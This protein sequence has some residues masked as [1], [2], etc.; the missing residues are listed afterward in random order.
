MM[1]TTDI[2]P[3]NEIARSE[4]GSKVIAW[5]AL[6]TISGHDMDNVQGILMD[7]MLDNPEYRFTTEVKTAGLEIRWNRKKDISE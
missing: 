7:L 6:Q 2:V 3:K 4:T 1:A 5:S